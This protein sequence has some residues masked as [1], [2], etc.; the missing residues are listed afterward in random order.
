MFDSIKQTLFRNNFQILE[1]FR[2]LGTF[3]SWDLLSEL[4]LYTLATYVLFIIVD[5]FVL[6]IFFFLSCKRIKKLTKT[7]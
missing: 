4:C 2:T 1:E 6:C 7:E 3:I 5:D